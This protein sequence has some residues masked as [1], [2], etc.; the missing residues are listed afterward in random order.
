[1]ATRFVFR[2]EKERKER[3]KALKDGTTMGV[4]GKIVQEQKRPK[5]S[6]PRYT[7]RIIRRMKIDKVSHVVVKTQT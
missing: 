7:K 2:L 5:P 1:M 4:E 6:W 3:E